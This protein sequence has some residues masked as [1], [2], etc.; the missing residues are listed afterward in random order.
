[1]SRPNQTSRCKISREPRPSELIPFRLLPLN[2]LS[3]R[4]DA[5]YKVWY[6]I[7]TLN[8]YSRSSIYH[9]MQ[10]CIINITN[11]I[12]AMGINI[13]SNCGN[14]QNP[15]VVVL[16]ECRKRFAIASPHRRIFNTCGG[17]IALF[18]QFQF[19]SKATH[20]PNIQFIYMMDE[21]ENTNI[22]LIEI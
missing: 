16:R 9:Y 13:F 14:V 7:F 1:M 19:W 4:L 20:P 18:G 3:N 5:S 21:I 17:K 22:Y 6:Y 12:L 10:C 15:V 8:I 11:V 2:V